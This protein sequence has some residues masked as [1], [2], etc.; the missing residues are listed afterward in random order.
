ML[1]HSEMEPPSRESIKR[2][3]PQLWTLGSSLVCAK[4]NAHG[5]HPLN[6]T[7]VSWQD[8]NSTFHLLPRDESILTTFSDGDSAID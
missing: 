6:T 7:I 1:I 8:G 2:I 5:V 3:N 4:T